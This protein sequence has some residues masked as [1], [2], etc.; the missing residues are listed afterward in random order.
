MK[1]TKPVVKFIFISIIIL[2]FISIILSVKEKQTSLSPEEDNSYSEENTFADS[3]YT[4]DQEVTTKQALDLLSQK[5]K[6]NV[7]SEEQSDVVII[8]PEIYEELATNGEATVIV[9]LKEDLLSY[10]IDEV[11]TKVA[12]NQDTVLENLN[13]ANDEVE[14]FRLIH[15]YEVLNGFSGVIDEKGLDSLSKNPLVKSVHLER[16]L[17]PSLPLSVPLINANDV[18]TAQTNLGNITGTGQ[19][20][21]VIDTGIDYTHPDLGGCFG[22]GCKVKGGF[23]YWNNDND[24]MD[25]GGH[26]THVAGIAAANGNVKGVAPNADLIGLKVCN[27]G[28]CLTG[29]MI[30]GVDYCISNVNTLGTDVITMSIGDLGEYGPN[31]GTCPSWIDSQFRL[32]NYLNI[33]VT[34]ASG[35]ERRRNGTAY[36]ACSPNAISVGASGFQGNPPTERIA[37]FSN[38]GPNLD[39]V[40]PGSGIYSTVLNGSYESYSGT[41]MATPHVA[42][43]I[44]LLKQLNPSL[45][46]FQLKTVLRQSGVPIVD[47]GNG[48]G[49]LTFPRIDSLGAVNRFTSWGNDIRLTSQSSASEDSSL[50]VD[51]SGN[52]HIAWQDYRDGNWEIYYTKLDNVGNTL[53]EDTRLTT[54]LT[55]SGRPSLAIDNQGKVNIAWEDERDGNSEIY[56]TKLDSVGNT[57]VEDTRLT[58]S[59]GGSRYSSLDIDEQN[60]MHIAW[61]DYRDGNW[62]IY[63]TKLN[64]VGNTLVEDTRLTNSSA[65]STFP[66]LSVDVLGIIYLVWQDYRNGHDWDIYYTKLNNMGNTL[67]DDL[68][69]TVDGAN[70]E[71]PSLIADVQN[72]AITWEDNR[73]GNKEIYYTKLNN[74]GVTLVDDLRLT[75]DGSNS[76]HS[77]AAIDTQGNVHFAWQDLRGG[78]YGE[79]YY[80]KLN[81]IGNTL[82][83][84]MRLTANSAFS[85]APSL[86]VD[87]QENVHVTWEDNRD[88]NKE[89][90]YKNPSSNVVRVIPPSSLVLAGTPTLGSSVSLQLHSP[91]NANQ[92]YILALSR[93]TSPGISFGNHHIPLNADYVFAGSISNPS[94][95]G[96]SS[97]SIGQL[98]SNGRATV[99]L[100]VPNMQWLSGQ[101]FY[102]SV[103]ILDAQGQVSGISNAV[104]INII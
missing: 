11:K 76:Q 46:P 101:T 38:T 26:G 93:G 39:V 94:A 104:Q 56:Y 63:Y 18:W 64:S 6:Q 71:N 4:T 53:I 100:N 87:S 9:W 44:A 85:G 92:N 66:S 49:G 13:E 8:E 77:S 33:P 5:M 57:L 98:D 37:Y 21:C 20:V 103:V 88:G 17:Y 34:V 19:T 68:R 79:I 1:K 32:A 61:Q 30:A 25:D 24:P 59:T 51:S 70:S 29:A 27:M 78:G 52:L 47:N 23:D 67:V 58:S 41:S 15:K 28:G 55:T 48:G 31:S 80:T 40:A 60:N 10:D 95:A 62:E 2:V 97:N 72:A 74:Q 54:S 99:F 16:I 73:D 45:T 7:A 89:I 12:E 22:T 42:G 84:D 102:G 36:P 50:A 83:D 86:E 90:Y 69:L 43:T 14:N 65:S 82:V 81:N 75:S 35:N 3:I 96:L 91:L